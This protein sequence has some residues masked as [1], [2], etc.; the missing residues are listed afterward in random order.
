MAALTPERKQQLEQHLQDARSA[1]HRLMMGESVRS[2]TD[3]NGEQISYTSANA[4][5]LAAYIRGLED[6]LG[7]NPRAN[8]PLGFFF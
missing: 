7:L 4:A 3:Q 1:Y 5:S 2:F 6:Q 8:R